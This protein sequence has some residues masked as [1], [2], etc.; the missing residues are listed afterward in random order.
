MEGAIG[1]AE[2]AADANFVSVPKPVEVPDAPKVQG[3]SVSQEQLQ[4]MEAQQD[5]AAQARIDKIF[6][7]N[8]GKQPQRR[9]YHDTQVD[10]RS[11]PEVT[12]AVDKEAIAELLET[13][14]TNLKGDANASA[15][16]AKLFFKRF[17][18]PVDALAEIGAVRADGPTQSIEK[19]HTPVQ[20]AFYDGMTQNSAIQASLWV[21]NNLSRQARNEV[22]DAKIAARIDPNDNRSDAYLSVVKAAKAVVAS[23]AR[24]VRR[25]LAKQEKGTA[26]TAR[27]R[28]VKKQLD[29][30]VE[31]PLVLN[32]P[33][34]IRL[35]SGQEVY[36]ITTP[37]KVYRRLKLI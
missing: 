18:R 22:R 14:D 26:E 31:V 27:K 34:P 23:D 35:R 29:K 2:T 13:S 28:E 33:K 5:A 16:A 15:R 12:T 36:R 32:A 19:D 25:Q 17:R 37:Q 20:F 11:A 8:R 6:E 3:A 10:P 30:S 24:K 1:G 4:A 7:S 9:E 21:N